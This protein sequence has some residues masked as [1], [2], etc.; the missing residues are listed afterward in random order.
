[1]L[2]LPGTF[3][4]G[5]VHLA[6]HPQDPQPRI[7][8]PCTGSRKCQGDNAPPPRFCNKHKSLE[9]SGPLPKDEVQLAV[10]LSFYY[11]T[12]PSQVGA[13]NVAALW[14]S[15]VLA[16]FPKSELLD[17]ST[18]EHPTKQVEQH[19]VKTFSS[20]GGSVAK[21]APSFANLPIVEGLEI[22]A[23]SATKL[24]L[25]QTSGPHDGCSGIGE[26]SIYVHETCG[27]EQGMAEND[28]KWQLCND[29]VCSKSANAPEECTQWFGQVDTLLRSYIGKLRG[30]VLAMK[31]ACCAEWKHV[32]DPFT[33]ASTIA[34][35]TNDEGKYYRLPHQSTSQTEFTME[36][37]AYYVCG[38][39]RGLRD[40][41]KSRP[42]LESNKKCKA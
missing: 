12:H 39:D 38:N 21:I 13:P 23:H 35:C 9:P 22:R 32:R 16:A 33:M 5:S 37:Q 40:K 10:A 2:A 8:S 34:Q 11:D 36:D 27:G 15:S 3:G 42:R 1:M 28:I 6:C 7:G 26:W 17:M 4:G 14:A 25:R 41:L 20:I 31:A 30:I 19:F 18:P 29:E 24:E